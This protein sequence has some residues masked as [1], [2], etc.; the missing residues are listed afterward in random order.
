MSEASERD[1][2]TILHSAFAFVQSV[3]ANKASAAVTLDHVI[4]QQV[5]F[6]KSGE[7]RPIVDSTGASTGDRT[8]RYDELKQLQSQVTELVTAA[9]SLAQE[10]DV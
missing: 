7:A 1:A 2:R 9:K 8:S 10:Y 6:L 3:E 5:K 4:A